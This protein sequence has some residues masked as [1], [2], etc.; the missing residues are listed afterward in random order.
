M[1]RYLTLFLCASS[2]KACSKLDIWFHHKTFVEVNS[3]IMKDTRQE[4]IELIEVGYDYNALMNI[5]NG[6]EPYE[7]CQQ[8]L[9]M[10]LED[11]DTTV[12]IVLEDDIRCYECGVRRYHITLPAWWRP[13]TIAL[14]FDE[15]ELDIL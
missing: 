7:G 9:I 8:N 3:K 10:I 14:C 15:N 11:P 2:Y 5:G 4:L 1:Q 13:G 6:W 12:H